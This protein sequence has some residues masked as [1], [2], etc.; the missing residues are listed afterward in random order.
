MTQPHRTMMSSIPAFCIN[1]DTSTDR[2]ER[3]KSR[4]KKMGITIERWAGATPMTLGTLQYASYLSNTQRACAKSHYD[5]WNYIVQNNIPVTLI[6]EDDAVFRCDSIDILNKRLDTI[7]TLDSEWD[8]L[9]LNA[10]EEALPTETWVKAQKQFLTG[11][12]I[13]SLRGATELLNL[14][15]PTLYASDWMTNLLQRRGHSYTYFPWLVIQDGE[16]SLIRNVKKIDGESG[17]TA[18]WNKVVRL[19]T[20][21]NYPLEENYEF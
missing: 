4:S 20:K 14:S 15:R 21:Y 6:L 7:G 9:V 10:S 19:L 1:V 8:M 2:W 18:D 17:L 11:G 13:L 16:D 3:M 12:Y 5:I